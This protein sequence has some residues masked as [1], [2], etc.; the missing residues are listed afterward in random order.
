MLSCVQIGLCIKSMALCVDK[1]QF[2]EKLEELE[3]KKGNG[4]FTVL[5]LFCV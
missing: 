5:Y 3:Q 2:Y 1:E 4:K